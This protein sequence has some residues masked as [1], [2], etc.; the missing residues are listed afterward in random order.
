MRNGLIALVFLAIAGTASAQCPDGKCSLINGLPLS[1][2]TR[3]AQRAV[4]QTA[5]PPLVRAATAPVR[6]AVAVTRPVRV[7]LL[8][9]RR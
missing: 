3:N 7:G 9:I 4:R 2:A 5:E 8:R 6:A 1:Q